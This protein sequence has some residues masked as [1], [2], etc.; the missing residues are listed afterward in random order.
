MRAMELDY[1][2]AAIEVKSGKIWKSRPSARSPSASPSTGGTCSILLRTA[3][4]FYL[5]AFAYAIEGTI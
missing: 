1:G 4:A 2:P 3:A 5:A